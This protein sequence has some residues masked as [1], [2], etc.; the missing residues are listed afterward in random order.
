M[1]A[2]RNIVILQIDYFSTVLSGFLGGGF[3][4]LGDGFLL[5]GFG[6]FFLILF[7]TGLPASES[8]YAFADSIADLWKFTHAEHDKD[9]Y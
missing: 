8:A 2:K 3:L 1:A 5:H 6:L 9:Y 4:T 7:I